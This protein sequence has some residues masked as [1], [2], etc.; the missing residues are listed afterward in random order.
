MRSSVLAAMRVLCLLADAPAGALAALTPAH[1]DC[2][3]SR[4]GTETAW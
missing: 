3:L 4:K 1:N 2:F